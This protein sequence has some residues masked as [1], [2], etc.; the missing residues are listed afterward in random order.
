V[1]SRPV[2]LVSLWPGTLGI[3]V[4]TS[5]L[6]SPKLWSWRLGQISIFCQRLGHARPPLP[7]ALVS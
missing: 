3:L 2:S 1:A 7:A 6:S 5:Q 4:P